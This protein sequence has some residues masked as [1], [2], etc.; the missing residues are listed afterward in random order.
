M[1]LVRK[2]HEAFG[3]PAPSSPTPATPEQLRLRLRLIREEAAEV[4]EIIVK[5]I[6]EKQASN[7][8]ALMG[9][10]L[11]ELA[12]LRVVTEGTAIVL[13]LDIDSAFA[14]VMD[15]N[16]SKLGPDGV[17]ILREDGKVLKGPAYRPADM[18][19]FVPPIVDGSADEADA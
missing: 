2:F 18:L 16:M 10:L 9:D 17:P 1:N 12:D 14:E 13:G 19:Q 15:S 4:E 5:M 11:K 6:H 8:I 3:A 7:Q